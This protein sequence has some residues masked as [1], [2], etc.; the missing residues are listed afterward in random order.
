MADNDDNNWQNNG[1]DQNVNNNNVID[2][3][4]EE[5][6]DDEDMVL[7]DNDTT[8]LDGGVASDSNN[9]AGGSSSDCDIVRAVLFF[10]RVV[11]SCACF[12]SKSNTAAVDCFPCCSFLCCRF[13]GSFHLLQGSTGHCARSSH[14][15]SRH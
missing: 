8:T 3:D 1:N 7:N 15:A 10:Y 4:E 11:P 9:N 5:E 2:E 12:H 14:H 6:D 13:T